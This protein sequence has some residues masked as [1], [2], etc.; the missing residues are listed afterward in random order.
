MTKHTSAELSTVLDKLA[1][2]DTFREH[3]LGN[4]V[5]ALSALGIT[6]DPAHVPAVR[7]LPSKAS[8]AA[9]QTTLQNNVVGKDTMIIFL[10][11]GAVA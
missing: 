10:L 5:A 3:L 11:S 1:S 9:D 4:P 6:I 7:S 2:D 8:I